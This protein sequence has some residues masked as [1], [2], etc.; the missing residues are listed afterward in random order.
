VPAYKSLTYFSIGLENGTT[1]HMRPG[2][3]VPPS[4][5]AINGHQTS[6]WLALGNVVLVDDPDPVALE[7]AEAAAAPA[8]ADPQ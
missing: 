2:D 8:S 7:K 5:A 4:F 6:Q 1:L 3:Y